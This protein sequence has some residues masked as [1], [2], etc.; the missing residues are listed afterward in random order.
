MDVTTVDLL[1]DW[2]GETLTHHMLEVSA[3]PVVVLNAD[4]RIVF[5]S[6]AAARLQWSRV[7]LIGTE[8][9]ELVHPDDR[10]PGAERTR[11]GG[12]ARRQVRIRSGDRWVETTMLRYSGRLP[13]HGM[14]GGQVSLVVLDGC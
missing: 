14:R 1:A 9:A 4:D 13:N 2:I 11:D 3:E 7:D 12:V 5:V 6:R 8:W 10:E